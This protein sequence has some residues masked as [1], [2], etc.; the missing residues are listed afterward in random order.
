MSNIAEVIIDLPLRGKNFFHYLI[1]ESLQP[2][3]NF[4]SLVIVPF[5]KTI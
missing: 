5:G 1:P 2:K 4:G 3:I